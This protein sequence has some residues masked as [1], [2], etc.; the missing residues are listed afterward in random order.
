MEN[1]FWTSENKTRYSI[2]KIPIS[3]VFGDIPKVKVLDT[4]IENPKLDY[5]KKGL[6]EAARISKSTLYKLWDKL[7]EEE[8]VQKTW[9]RHLP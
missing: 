6:A 5:S 1:E 4:L 2:N 9:K 8:I 7:E 3:K